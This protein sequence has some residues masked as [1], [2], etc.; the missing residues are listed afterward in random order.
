M[1]QRHHLYISSHW[2][3]G[4]QDTNFQGYNSV[5]GSPIEFGPQILHHALLSILLSRFQ[6]PLAFFVLFCFVPGTQVALSCPLTFVCIFP[7]PKT[8]PPGLC[9]LGPSSSFGSLLKQP[10]LPALLTPHPPPAS[11]IPYCSALVSSQH[12]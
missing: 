7:L 11:L 1:S 4:L 10:P 5:Y 9:L 12:L 8:L 2:Q 6:A 3:L